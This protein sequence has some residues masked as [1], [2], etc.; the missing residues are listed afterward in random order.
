[1]RA[2][3]KKT[4]YLHPVAVRNEKLQKQK[5]RRER[6]TGYL[7]DDAIVRI[8]KRRGVSLA[9]SEEELIQLVLNTFDSTPHSAYQSD[10]Y[11][12]PTVASVQKR[13]PSL[14]EREYMERINDGFSYRP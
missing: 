2:D 3:F 5:E 14:I 11:E 8:L 1:L 4:N 6:R 9:V 10:Y 13:F 7:I 12:P